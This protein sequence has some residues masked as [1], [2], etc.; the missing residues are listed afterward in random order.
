MFVIPNITDDEPSI[1]TTMFVDTNI[2]P[3]A[4]RPFLAERD[5]RFEV[6]WP[7]LYS[8]EHQYPSPNVLKDV[9]LLA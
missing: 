3:P 2:I 8:L 5:A 6:L 1:T 7:Q 9:K 4:V